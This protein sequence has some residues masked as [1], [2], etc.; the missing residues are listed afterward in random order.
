M[1]EGSWEATSQSNS[2]E[3]YLKLTGTSGDCLVQPLLQHHQLQQVDKACALSDFEYLQGWRLRHFPGQPVPV[4]DCPPHKNVFLLCFKWNFLCFS[5]WGQS[6]CLGGYLIRSS[7][8]VPAGAGGGQGWGPAWWVGCSITTSPQPHGNLVWRCQDLL[9]LQIYKSFEE[10]HHWTQTFQ[11]LN[12]RWQEWD[13]LCGRMVPPESHHCS[14]NRDTHCLPLGQPLSPPD[15]CRC[16]QWDVKDAS[17]MLGVYGGSE[18]R[19]AE[20][21]IQKLLSFF[22]QNV[23]EVYLHWVTSLLVLDSK[24]K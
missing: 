5:W 12:I 17:A 13:R 4:L 23:P 7:M 2:I 15:C 10:G 21:F 9:S 14:G 8:L 19:R 20:I 24:I 11:W 16:W 18:W 6:Q 22:S 1:S 3:E